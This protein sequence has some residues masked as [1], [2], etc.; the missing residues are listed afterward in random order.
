M[1][2]ALRSFLRVV[3]LLAVVIGRDGRCA[4]PAPLDVL[5]VAPHSDD[6]AIGCAGVILRTITE[7]KRPGVVVL[8]A[9]DGFPKAAAAAARKSIKELTPDDF[10]ALAAMRQRHSI[11]AMRQLGVREEDLLFLGYP[12]GGLTAI[13]NASADEPYRQPHTGKTET[14]GPVVADYHRQVHGRPA[15]YVRASVIGD[16]AEI[17]RNCRPS[18]IYV[19]GEADHHPDHRLAIRYVR[20]AAHAAEYRGDLWTYVVHGAPP[21]APPDLRLTLN[22]KELDTKRTLLEL[23]EVG[24]SPVHDRLA[25]TYAR[26]EETFWKSSLHLDAAK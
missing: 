12:D 4:D 5:I 19:T 8:T 17:I 13:Y 16:L 14:Y 2:M 20:D 6:E 7:N 26:R 24:V 18:A 10:V 11:Q 9:G 25:E 3:L 1:K 23:Y 15:P 21:A 22:E